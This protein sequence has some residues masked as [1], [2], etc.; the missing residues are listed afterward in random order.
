MN[1]YSTSFFNNIKAWQRY[2]KREV[3]LNIY[4][5]PSYSDSFSLRETI[6]KNKNNTILW[7][8]DSSRYSVSQRQINTNLYGIY[9][10]VYSERMLKI[11]LPAKTLTIKDMVAMFPAW[12]RFSFTSLDSTK[13]CKYVLINEDKFASGGDFLHHALKT[14]PV[15]NTRVHGGIIHELLST[16]LNEEKDGV[17]YVTAIENI[18]SLMF[19]C[20]RPNDRCNAVFDVINSFYVNPDFDLSYAEVKCAMSR[21]K[22]Q[23]ILKEHGDVFT[24][25]VNRK[26]SEHLARAIEMHPYTSLAVLSYQS[27]FSTIES[28]RRNFLKFIGISLKKYQ[29]QSRCAHGKWQKTYCR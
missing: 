12:E 26:R 16:P 3:G 29:K 15:I 19:S 4:I 10:I 14:N 9:M 23:Y 28:A 11:E 13:K 22:I 20:P 6:H 7:T 18:L 2:V 8:L 17:N 1:C 25:V 5:P 24:K 27:G 21:R